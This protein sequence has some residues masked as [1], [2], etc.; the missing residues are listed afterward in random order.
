ME[1]EILHAIQTIRTTT[2]DNI[3]VY[4]TTL[5]DY[6]LIWIFL[7]MGLIAIR[8]TRF[9][10]KVSMLALLFE[11]GIVTFTL[12]PLVDRVRPCFVEAIQSPLLEMAYTDP[13]FPSGHAASSFAVA[14]AIFCC[15]KKWGVLA[16]LA[17]ALMGFTRLYLFVH[18]PTDV[19]A[20][21]V[22]GALCGYL[23]WRMYDRYA[24]VKGVTH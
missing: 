23:A 22:I 4:Y 21:A 1:F 8:S 18:Y 17:A 15:N 24:T 19:L 13:S 20:G 7:A 9:M 2:L 11:V 3:M 10:G 14:T 12:K 6:G 16:L 5:G